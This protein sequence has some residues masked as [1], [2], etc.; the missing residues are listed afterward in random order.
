MI[1]T[2]TNAHSHAACD[3]AASAGGVDVGG[4]GE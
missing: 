4:V 1:P 2:N 3:G